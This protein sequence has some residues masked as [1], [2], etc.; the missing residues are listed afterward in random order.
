MIHE[1]GVGY[2]AMEMRLGQRHPCFCRNLRIIP[3]A[4]LALFLLVAV[5]FLDLAWNEPQL[6]Q[7]D[8]ARCQLHANPPIGAEPMSLEVA[9]VAEPFLPLVPP[10]RVPLIGASIFVPPRV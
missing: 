8:D 10:D 5:P 4:V 9:L 7:S 1:W 3:W 2:H 6:G